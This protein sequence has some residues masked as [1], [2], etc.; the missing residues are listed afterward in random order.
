ML[1]PHSR[2]RTLKLLF[3]FYVVLLI[4]GRLRETFSVFAV[5]TSQNVFELGEGSKGEQL[6]FCGPDDFAIKVLA[7]ECKDG[8]GEQVRVDV[9]EFG[10]LDAEV[11]EELSVLAHVGAVLRGHWR[12]GLSAAQH[13]V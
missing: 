2:S 1:G 3:I 8:A 12:E 9:N 4:L 13:A 10:L 5:E 11:R 6:H 7:R